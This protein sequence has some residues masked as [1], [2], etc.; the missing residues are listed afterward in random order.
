[1]LSFIRP[2]RLLWSTNASIGK[3]NN[4]SVRKRKKTSQMVKQIMV[5]W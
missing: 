5:M 2:E 1:M 3:G 4:A